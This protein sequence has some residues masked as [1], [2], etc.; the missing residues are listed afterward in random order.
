MEGKR[1]IRT[2]EDF[3]CDN[4]GFSVSGN[5]F[6]NHC[7]KCL[8]SKHVDVNPGDRTE[9]CQGLMTPILVEKDSLGWII[10]HQCERC[11]I[12]RRKRS[13]VSD[14]FDTLLSVVKK[15]QL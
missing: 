4:C 15:S 10:V 5:G 8:F 1:F 7:P 11:Q 12:K 2:I 14:S 3:V 13:D 6:T 9:V